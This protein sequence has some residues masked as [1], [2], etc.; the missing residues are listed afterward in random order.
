MGSS[1]RPFEGS[2]SEAQGI[3]AVE[4]ATF[5]ESPY[6]ADE[7]RTMLTQGQQRAWLAM[8]GPD[9]VGF[10]VAF[11]T[12]G[13][14]GP[15]WEIDLL[16]V[17]PAWRGHGLATALVRAATGHG[18][19]VASRARAVVATDN[20][21]SAR[22]FTRAGFHATEGKHELLVRRP[23]RSVRV[24]EPAPPRAKRSAGLR[25]EVLPSVTVREIAGPEGVE[26]LLLQAELNGQETGLAE[27]IEV[28]TLLYRGF[29][30]ESLLATSHTVRQALVRYTLERAA[31]KRLDEV[32]AMVPQQDALLKEC[33]LSAG[34]S[35]L[36]NFRW[37]TASLSLPSASLT[38]PGPEATKLARKCSWHAEQRE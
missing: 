17:H 11:P 36:G 26:A 38:P 34:F 32:G 9:A 2:L 10:V 1:I 20:P 12:H 16:A 31:I 19:Q 27:L 4:Q 13:L 6:S 14:S 37:F 25:A 35:S 24:F 23:R 18:A 3:L 8:K 33:L 15:C 28:Q 7:L 22:A 30:I 5:H 29:W 21:A